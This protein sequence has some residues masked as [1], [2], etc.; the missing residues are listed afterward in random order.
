MIKVN[1]LKEIELPLEYWEEFTFEGENGSIYRVSISNE[2]EILG[3]CTKSWE[4]SLISLNYLY[5]HILYIKKLPQKPFWAEQGDIY[6]FI[7]TDLD[8]ICKDDFK[9]A[10][11]YDIMRR[12]LGNCFK[13][14]NITK[15][16]IDE[17][18]NKLNNKEIL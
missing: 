3:K 7:S 8:S 5:C 13:T 1:I 17:Y 18:L 11:S 14:D 15:E 4:V 6:Y 9:D 12:K 16:Q 10:C 2:V